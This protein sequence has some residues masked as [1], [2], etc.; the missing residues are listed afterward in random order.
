MIGKYDCSEY[1]I[2]KGKIMRVE[3]TE[4]SL[5]W[6]ENR[7]FI[8][9]RR[10]V[11]CHLL[12]LKYGSN[13]PFYCLVFQFIS[14]YFF[15]PLNLLTI[16]FMYRIHLIRIVYFSSFFTSFFSP[17]LIPLLYFIHMDYRLSEK[18]LPSFLP[19]VF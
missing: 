3:M 2:N 7:K 15:C 4:Y 19:I 1:L 5:E 16:S 18:T 9:V 12:A 14:F 17:M 10:A 13:L 11:C 8:H 6:K